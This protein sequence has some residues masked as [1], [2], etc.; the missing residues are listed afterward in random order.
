MKIQKRHTS[1]SSRRNT[2]TR[3]WEKVGA[4]GAEAA[5]LNPRTSLTG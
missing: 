4:A 2:D 3:S 1:G 5:R